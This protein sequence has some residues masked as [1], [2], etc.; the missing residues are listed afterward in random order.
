[1]ITVVLDHITEGIHVVFEIITERDRG[2]VNRVLDGVVDDLCS[3]VIKLLD[4]AVEER[5]VV[6][7]WILLKK[8]DDDVE[9]NLEGDAG[10][11]C[12]AI[13]ELHLLVGLRREDGVV[14]IDDERVVTHV[15]PE[16]EE[17][18]VVESFTESSDRCGEARDN[19]SDRRES[20]SE[21]AEERSEEDTG[22]VI[23]GD[24]SSLKK[25]E[26]AGSLHGPVARVDEGSLHC[27]PDGEERV[28]EEGTEELHDGEGSVVRR[29]LEGDEEREDHVRGHGI[30]LHSHSDVEGPARVGR[31][32]SDLTRI[33]AFSREERVACSRELDGVTSLSLEFIVEDGL[34]G[35][36]S[37][38]VVIDESIVDREDACIAFGVGDNKGRD[39]SAEGGVVRRPRTIVVNDRLHEARVA[40]DSEV[41][42]VSLVVSEPLALIVVGRLEGEHVVVGVGGGRGRGGRWSVTLV[43]GKLRNEV[44]QVPRVPQIPHG[45]FSLDD[46]TEYPSQW[47]ST[48]NQQPANGDT[49]HFLLARLIIHRHPGQW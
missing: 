38:G 4:D 42:V 19:G 14:K 35:G 16:V 39:G 21:T 32:D 11:R 43:A 13:H 34:E 1:M 6:I 37:K 28:G 45:I 47:R 9:E 26:T 2:N 31:R 8:L 27:A 20:V 44:S 12:S 22:E 30:G 41:G 3:D 33:E 46:T 36:L 17:E 24:S 49:R 7:R 40:F 15:V 10:D 25:G 29:E 5:R 18:G 23:G 48:S